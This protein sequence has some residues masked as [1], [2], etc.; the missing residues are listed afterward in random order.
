MAVP[1][2]TESE[3]ERLLKAPNRQTMTGF[4]DYAE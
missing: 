2:F 4:R 1:T 3:I